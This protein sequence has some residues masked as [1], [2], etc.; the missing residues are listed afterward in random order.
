MVRFRAEAAGSSGWAMVAD[1]S[2]DGIGLILDQGIEPGAWLLIELRCGDAGPPTAVRARVCH[3]DQLGEDAWSIG[4][5]LATE[6]T[7]ADLTDLAC[8]ELF[9]LASD[10]EPGCAAGLESP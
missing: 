3:A 6:L 4:C 10:E 5:A 7:D 8:A 2:A 9:A 1:L